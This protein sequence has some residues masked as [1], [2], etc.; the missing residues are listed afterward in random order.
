MIANYTTKNLNP[1]LIWLLRTVI[2]PCVGSPIRL[3]YG[4][5][6]VDLGDQFVALDS[7]ASVKR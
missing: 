6:G 3:S 1:K 7:F 4:T 2:L 5:A